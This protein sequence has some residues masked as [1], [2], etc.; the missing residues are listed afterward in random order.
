M[1]KPRRLIQS[2]KRATDILN[3][4]IQEENALGITEL[5]KRMGLAKT[6]IQ[7]IVQT[8]EALNYLEKDPFTPKYRLG[9][10]VFQ[11]GMQYAANMDIVNIGKVWM[12]RLS[13]QFR[14]PINV[15]MLVGSQVVVALRVDPENSFMSYPQAGSVIPLHTTCIGKILFAFLDDKKCMS[16]LKK[17]HFEKLTPNT[18]DTLEGF[19]KEIKTVKKSQISFEN[20]E[21]VTGMAGIG[22]PLMN[23]T[24]QVIAAFAVTGNADNILWIPDKTHNFETSLSHIAWRYI[25]HELRTP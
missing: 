13:F 12:E 20:Q 1:A 22:A 16:I 19:L 6:T 17:Y 10:M 11:L 23:H 7:S 2:I 3:I 24:N 25:K 14:E 5:A 4:F 18:I 9:P 21:S 15:G 8:L